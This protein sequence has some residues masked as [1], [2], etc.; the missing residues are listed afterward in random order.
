M[1]YSTPS[2]NVNLGYEALKACLAWYFLLLSESVSHLFPPLYWLMARTVMYMYDL[3]D[4]NISRASR[5][6]SASGYLLLTTDYSFLRTS[7]TRGGAVY[8]Y[9]SKLL[10]Y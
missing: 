8:Y 5:G 3:C 9:Y 6:V 10:F 4:F 1:E 7:T 2:I